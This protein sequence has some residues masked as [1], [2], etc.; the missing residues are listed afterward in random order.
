MTETEVVTEA[1]V[2][3]ETEVVTETPAVTAPE[4][5]TETVAE[6]V[7]ETAAPET[8]APA[9]DEGCA[10]LVGMGAV[11]VMAIAAAAVLFKR[12]EQ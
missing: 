6:T 5:V 7:P 3:T 9:S 8:D 10:S 4:T 12:K 2:V 11:S 1:P